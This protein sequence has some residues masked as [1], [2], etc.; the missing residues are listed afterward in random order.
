MA[1]P[2]YAFAKR[3]RELAKKLKVEQKRQRKSTGTE[4]ESG[5]VDGQAGDTADAEAGT[6]QAAAEAGA[7]KIDSPASGG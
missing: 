6:E 1:K 3:Q 4:T 7:P 5:E 2:N